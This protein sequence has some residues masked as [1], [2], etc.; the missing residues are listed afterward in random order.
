MGDR[1]ADAGVADLFD[2][3]GQEAHFAGAQFVDVL[4]LGCE[5]AEL[6]DAVLAA[7][8][9]HLDLVAFAHLAVD[10][11]DQDDDAEIGVVIAVHQHG[12]ERR[13]RVAFRGG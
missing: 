11:A 10:H 7:G 6:V 4:H 5:D 3:R 8:R 12:L 1:V 13:V 9:H 2:R